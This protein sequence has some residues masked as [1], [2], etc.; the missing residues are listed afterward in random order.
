[1]RWLVLMAAGQQ[2]VMPFVL[3]PFGGDDYS[4]SANSTDSA[5]APA[6]YAF[7]IWGGIYLGAL[8][9]AWWQA[10]GGGRTDAA[11]ARA[12][13]PALG[14]YSGSSLWLYCAAIGPLWGTMPLLAVM[15]ACA[16]WAL[17]AA[18]FTNSARG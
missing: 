7:A 9:F 17:R 13:W 16:V 18:M 8:V 11:A 14:L 5:I 1:M 2:I 10:L 15:A 6:G 4:A 12:A 3:N